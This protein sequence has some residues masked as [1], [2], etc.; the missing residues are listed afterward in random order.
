MLEIE[1][2]RSRLEEVRKDFEVRYRFLTAAEGGRKTGPPGQGYRSDWSYEDKGIRD[3]GR[4]YVI[5][6]IFLDETGKIIE[7]NTFVPMEGIAQMFILND[8]LRNS[9]HLGR[10]APGVRGYFMEGPNRVAE[11]TVTRLLAIGEIPS[12]TD[13][14]KK[15]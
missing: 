13:F 7:P 1:E 3:T 5:W 6:P 2:Q 12:Q 11:A 4:L 10:I 9:L 14:A 8:E 15:D